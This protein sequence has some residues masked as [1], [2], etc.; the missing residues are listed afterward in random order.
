VTFS[1]ENGSPTAT[2]TVE[3]IQPGGGTETL[4]ETA[5]ATAT[6]QPTTDSTGMAGPGFTPVAAL[7]ALALA[8]AFLARRR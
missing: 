4:T 3:G 2:V 8:A 7:V 5:T 6:D 1:A